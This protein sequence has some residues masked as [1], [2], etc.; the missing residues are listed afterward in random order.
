MILV[1]FRNIR[2]MQIGYSRGSVER[3]RQTAVGLSTTATVNAF[4]GYI[5]ETFRDKADQL[6][7]IATRSP[8]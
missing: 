8:S 4:A 5:V 1:F 3:G 6:Y 7:Y 2:F